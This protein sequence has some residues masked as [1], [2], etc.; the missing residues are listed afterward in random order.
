MKKF[1]IL[2]LFISCVINAQKKEYK[3]TLA[4]VKKVQ[5]ETGTKTKVTVG[6]SNML[7]I[8]DL[9][10]S[11]SDHDNDHDDDCDNCNHNNRNHSKKK[12]DKTKGLTAIYPGGKDNT[13]GYG[14]AIFKEGNTLVVRD[15][16]S[17]FQRH[18]I[19]IEL[20]KTMN[21]SV[22]SGNLGSVN[23]EGFTSEVEVETNVG[24]IDM[25]N[26]TGPITAHTSVGPIN[27]EFNKVNQSSPISISSSVSEIDVTIPSNTKAD[28]ELKTNGTVYTNFDIQIPTKKGMKNVSGIKRINSSINNGGVKIKLRSSMGNIYLRKK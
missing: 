17:H 23:V 4:G 28:L 14:F 19:H 21:M 15:L 22:D 6:T 11:H 5:I 3:H 20:P 26:V 2:L 8:K 24:R 18:G 13:N 9:K 1:T 27:I 12:S 25:K 10:S 7:V 16:K